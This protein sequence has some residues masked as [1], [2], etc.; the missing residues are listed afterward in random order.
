MKPLISVITVVYN[1][2]QYLQQTINSV[3]NQ[4]YANI[5]YI[6]VD[7]G[8]T[9]A[10][11]DIIEQN[12]SCIAQWVS[13]PDKGLYDAMNKGIR[14]AN[15]ELIGMINSDDWYELN[16]VEIIVAA[17]KKHPHKTIFH[18]HR[19]DILE[20][21]TKTIRKFHSSS[22]KF[23]Y[24]AMTYNHPSMFISPK[25]Y[26]EHLYN[27]NLRSLSDY[28]F[29]LTTFLK[30]PDRFYLIDHTFVNYRLDG[31]SANLGYIASN[32]EAYN[33][34]KQAG[35]SFIERVFAI[36]FSSF[37]NIFYPIFKVIK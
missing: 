2:E 16:A 4:T 31:I 10:T 18:A 9:D 33:A 34:R 13:E 14:L 28:E 3:A 15:G 17:Y 36:I 29:T 6:I 26:E 5:E 12:S 11:L 30:N 35:M 25:E 20:D 19:F 23:K 32:K 1:G 21:N 24:Y 27:I 37:V 7:G 8:S 22:F